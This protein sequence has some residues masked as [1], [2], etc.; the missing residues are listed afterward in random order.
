VI[1]EYSGGRR[2][3]ELY[4][5]LAEANPDYKI[6]V[7]DNASPGNFSSYITHQNAKNSW[8]G[9]GIID[10]L[11]LAEAEGAEY[12]FF[13]ANDIELINVPN[14][15][16]FETL[17]D[18]DERI[19]LVGAAITPDTTQARAYPWMVRR[20]S[21]CDRVVP[22]SDFLC[23]LIRI[24][25]VRQFGGFPPSKG[26][27]GYDWEFAS[28]ARFQQRSILIADHAVIRHTSPEPGD[29]EE[30]MLEMKAVYTQ[31]YGD[32][33]VLHAWR[34]SRQISEVTRVFETKSSSGLSS[35]CRLAADQIGTALR[36][37]EDQLSSEVP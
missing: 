28:Y 8:V 19:V 24:P 10:C 9:G 7:L 23:C 35:K 15:S 4:E 11:D 22:H 34:L 12:L 13:V 29:N 3:D 33:R 2:T 5:K 27:W 6:N 25:F 30:K 18:C 32:Y 36:L 1:L 20:S 16:R 37:L 26:G 14:I 17:A 21:N 31:L